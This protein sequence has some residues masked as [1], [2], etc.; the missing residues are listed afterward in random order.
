[1]V[2]LEHLRQTLYRHSLG[3]LYDYLETL[4]K[5]LGTDIG[6]SISP[7]SLGSSAAAV[8]AAINGSGGKFVRT[9]AVEVVTSSGE[10]HA[11][12]NTTFKVTVSKTSTSGVVNSPNVAGRCVITNGVGEVTLEYT[13]TWEA[14]DTAIITIDG[15]N[16]A[17][18]DLFD[19]GSWLST[20]TLVA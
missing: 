18:F 6:M 14:G 12:L 20:D 17:G 7:I 9:V 11:W 19:L 3:P 15:E 4:A 8:N 1:M 5:A 2:S 13:G 10:R 16:E